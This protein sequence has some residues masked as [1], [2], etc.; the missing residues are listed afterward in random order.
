MKRFHGRTGGGDH[1]ER[2]RTMAPK[3]GKSVVIACGLALVGIA[4]F[5]HFKVGEELAYPGRHLQEVKICNGD[6]ILPIIPYENTWDLPTRAVLYVLFLG[7]LFLGVAISADCF[8]AAIEVI[9]SATNEVE[10]GGE[11]IEVEVW[12]STVANLTLMALGSSAPEILLAV[13]ETVSLKFESGDLGPGCIVGSAA[14]NLL[15]ITAICISCLPEDQDDPTCLETRRIDEFGVFVITAIASLFAYLW[16]VITLAWVSA[17]QIEVWEAVVTFLMFPA[18]VWVSWAEDSGWWNWFGS[19]SV[20]PEDGAEGEGRPRGRLKS[21]SIDGGPA[22]RMS[23]EAAAMIDTASDS[24]EVDPAAAA[25]A[26]AQA[27]FKKKKKS[28]LQYRIQATRQMTGGKRILPTDKP[29][30]TIEEEVEAPPTTPLL[31]FKEAKYA[32]DESCDI[33][34]VTVV[35]TGVLEKACTVQFDTCDG[36]QSEGLGAQAGA[37]YVSASGKLEFAAGETEKPINIK[38]IDDNEW[39]P[40]KHF[41]VRLFHPT[42]DGSDKAEDVALTTATTHVTIMN[43]DDP[44][45]VGFAE[46]TVQAISSKKSVSV[47]LVLKYRRER[48]AW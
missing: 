18:L 41:Y 19:D 9:T 14:F 42:A 22:R 6:T 16:M 24:G 29:P 38:V 15:F 31:G 26:L 37:E 39:A 28:R 11:K 21:M 48:S 35:R 17:D 7:W 3:Y 33:C 40:D 13:V 36:D 12:N 4:C 20:T 2:I 43:D 32:V 47:T 1:S 23:K 5:T 44:G 8:M 10:V 46:H 30:S 45:T 34:V 27:Q 25:A